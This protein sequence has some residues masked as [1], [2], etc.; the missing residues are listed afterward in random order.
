MQIRPASAN[1]FATSPEKRNTLRTLSTE[2]LWW[3]LIIMQS[4]FRTEQTYSAYVF[5]T[6]LCFE[7]E[8]PVQ[9]MP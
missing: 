4:D 5:G 7:A 3:K 1:S 2:V 6:V 9:P 8:V